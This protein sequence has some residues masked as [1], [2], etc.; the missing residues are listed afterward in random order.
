MSWTLSATFSPKH[1]CQLLHRIKK[2][3]RKLWPRVLGIISEINRK[4]WKV[5][6]I[7]KG[8]N[9]I[10]EK[11]KCRRVSECAFCWAFVFEAFTHS[12]RYMGTGF[13][14]FN[15]MVALSFTPHSIM[16]DVITGY[17]IVVQKLFSF[18]S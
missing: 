11:R 14:H 4:G 17:K 12:L 18:S 9:K 1:T 16:K 3:S 8:E 2:P 15:P 7:R 5:K 13:V 6:T 10:P